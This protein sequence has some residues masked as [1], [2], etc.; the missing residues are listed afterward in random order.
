MILRVKEIVILLAKGDA[1]HCVLM[2]AEMDVKMDVVFHV[3]YGALIVLMVVKM[4][5]TVPV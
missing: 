3:G 1:V 4:V 2:D 5:V